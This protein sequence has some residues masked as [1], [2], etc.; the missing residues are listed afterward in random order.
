MDDLGTFYIFIIL[1]PSA[2]CRQFNDDSV[3]LNTHII[4]LYRDLHGSEHY[5]E[6]R[7]IHRSR[8]HVTL[9]CCRVADKQLSATARGKHAMAAVTANYTR[10]HCLL[11]DAGDHPR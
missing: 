9:Q 4:V 6:R 11:S 2:G 10:V 7:S 1:H 8:E 3:R 5:V